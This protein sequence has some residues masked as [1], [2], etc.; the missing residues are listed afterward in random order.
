MSAQLIEK[1]PISR[2]RQIEN[3]KQ[4]KLKRYYFDFSL[5]AFTSACFD[6][7]ACPCFA[8]FCTEAGGAVSVGLTVSAKAPDEAK[9]K[10]VMKA[11]FF[12]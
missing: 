5:P 6:F 7:A 3:A 8:G 10:A 4:K 9:I 1:G 2:P 11:K 12:M